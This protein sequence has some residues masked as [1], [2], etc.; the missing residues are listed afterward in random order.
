MRSAS[1][2]AWLAK[3]SEKARRRTTS[4]RQA[5]YAL[6]TRLTRHSS[7]NSSPCLPATSWKTASLLRMSR[8]RLC[9]ALICRSCCTTSAVICDLHSTQLPM[10]AASCASQLRIWGSRSM[11]WL[12]FMLSTAT[13]VS[14]GS[15]ASA[16]RDAICRTVSST[17][18]CTVLKSFSRHCR[19]DASMSSWPC[20]S[21]MRFPS[22]SRSTLGAVMKSDSTSERSAAK[23]ASRSATFTAKASR[24]IR[25]LSAHSRRRSLGMRS[26]S[27]RRPSA[28][29]AGCSSVA[30]S[31]SMSRSKPSSTSR[32]ACCSAVYFSMNALNTLQM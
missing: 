11:R 1:C 15:M 26:T 7:A 23:M 16:R 28:C 8:M 27:R 17:S 24:A 19:T 22:S 10:K 9:I 4:A 21:S 25:Q 6:G 30:P 13:H 2:A 32:C 5:R 3:S 18:F 20:A 29:A 12:W 31:C 14:V